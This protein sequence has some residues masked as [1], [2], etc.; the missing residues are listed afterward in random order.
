MLKRR[1][2]NADP[3]RP[4]LRST[5]A[6]A[7][8]P[9]REAAFTVEEKVVW[10]GAERLRRAA[11]AARG[12]LARIAR[13]LER[14][15][16]P[17]ER[18][19]LWPLQDRA[20][21]LG[22]SMRGHGTSIAAVGAI[23]FGVVL[24]TVVF[25]VG[26][27]SAG[28]RPVVIGAAPAAIETTAPAPDGTSGPLLHGAPPRFGVGSGLGVAESSVDGAGAAL[29]SVE[30]A[31]A[32][33][34]GSEAEAASAS[35]SAAGKPVP[36]GPAAMKVARRFAEA[37]VF[38]EIGQRTDR[39]ETVFDET[40]SA[41]LAEALGNRPPRLPAGSTVPKAKV[42]NLVPGPRRGHAYTVSVSLLRVGVTSELRLSMQK[43]AGTWNVTDVRG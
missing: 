20:T 2:I 28:T 26:G 11:G 19:V 35:A 22:P 4:S 33:T 13:P 39:A 41:P 10:P 9:V 32:T 34:A 36:A 42:L 5:V 30:G 27:G 8:E 40:A 14:I 6:A 21:G 24:L 31:S 3:D 37:F 16:W 15:V 7:T 18:F 29:A 12:P 23:L 1:Q 17:F 43:S 38:Y 25:T